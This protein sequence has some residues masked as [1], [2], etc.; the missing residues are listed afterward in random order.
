M[1]LAQ[2]LEMAGYL[3]NVLGIVTCLAGLTLA[4][5]PSRRP[6]GY[7]LA[8]LGFLL[9]ASPLLAQLLGLVPPPA[10]APTPLPG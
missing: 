6:L 3:L 10:M 9:A 7:A 8:G 5:H 4:R 1:S 2:F